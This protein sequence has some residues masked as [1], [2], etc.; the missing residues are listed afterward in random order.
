MMT[1]SARMGANLSMKWF[2]GCALLLLAALVVES[3]LLAYSMYVLLGLLV[4]SRLMARSWIG[5][6]TAER[7][8]N[9]T[10]AEVGETIAVDVT[11]NNGGLWPVPWVILED[12]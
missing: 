3:G 5:N 7:T 6:L 9:Q 12:L 2:L 11:V 10:A 4:V 1:V 8:C